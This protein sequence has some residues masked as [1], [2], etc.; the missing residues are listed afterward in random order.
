M[1]NYQRLTAGLLDKQ[2]TLQQLTRSKHPTLGST[3]ETWSDLA[4]VWAQIIESP[5]AGE[6]TGSAGQPTYARPHR[7]SIRWRSGVGPEMRLRLADGRLL[8]I[9]GTAE[10]GRREWLVLSCVEWRHQRP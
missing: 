4:T 3:V 2:V 7:V 9:N 10:L 8:Q 5:T 6:A 1:T